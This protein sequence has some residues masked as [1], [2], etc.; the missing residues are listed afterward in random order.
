M[1]KHLITFYFLRKIWSK[2]PDIKFYSFW[3]D[4]SYFWNY[5]SWPARSEQVKNDEKIIKCPCLKRCS[6]KKYMKFLILL[7]FYDRSKFIVLKKCRMQAIYIC[8]FRLP[9][10][11]I[12]VVIEVCRTNNERYNFKNS[13]IRISIKIYIGIQKMNKIRKF[14]P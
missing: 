6:K 8:N 5:T 14:V 1:P 13:K 7:T 10:Q 3:T 2:G 4:L 11:Q 12:T 9:W